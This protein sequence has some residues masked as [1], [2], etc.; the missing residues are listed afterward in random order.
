MP[1]PEP[2]KKIL[3]R[4]KTEI[5]PVKG[6]YIVKYYQGI[7]PVNGF[8]YRRYTMISLNDI[9]EGGR[10][11]QQYTAKI[12]GKCRRIKRE[13]NKQKKMKQLNGY[14]YC[15]S[16]DKYNHELCSAAKIT[17]KDAIQWALTRK[18]RLYLVKYRKDEQIG[19]K[20]RIRLTAE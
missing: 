14:Y 9:P 16:K 3:F 6:Y 18:S 12:S 5:K 4:W 19:K 15:L 11:R 2:K 1:L 17:R 13:R 8:P 10:K 20:R 7:N